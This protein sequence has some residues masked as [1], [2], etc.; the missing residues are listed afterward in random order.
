[1]SEQADLNLDPDAVSSPA[2]VLPHHGR[3]PI[4]I[5]RA[6]QAYRALMLEL[7]R[8]RQKIGWS[9]WQLEDAAGLNDGHFS[10]LLHGDRPSGRR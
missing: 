2:L 10:H 4:I 3:M 6:T 9:C 7:E 5:N 8:Q 1:M